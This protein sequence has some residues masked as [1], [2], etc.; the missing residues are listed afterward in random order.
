M[1]TPYDVGKA[2]VDAIRVGLE[3][4]KTVEERKEA[5]YQIDINRKEAKRKEQEA[6][7][8]RQDGVEEARRKKLQSILK[9]G[10]EKVNIAAGNIAL[11]SATT[12]NLMEDQK[13]NGELEALITLESSEKRAAN[14]ID[15]SQ[16]KY[17]NAALTSFKSKNNFVNSMMKSSLNFTDKTLSYSEEAARKNKNKS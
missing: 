4:K 3:V 5:K 16:E 6:A 11:S 10:D 15:Q 13:L 9:M 17:Q 8:E 2:V 7:Y 12:L 1:C 14:L